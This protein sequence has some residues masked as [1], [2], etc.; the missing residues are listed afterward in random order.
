MDYAIEKE[1]GKEAISPINHVRI[2]KI[3][4]LPCE[5]SG[6]AGDF[7]TSKYYQIEKKSCLM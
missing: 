7:P 1:L 6:M 4:L 5:L 3:M 2:Y